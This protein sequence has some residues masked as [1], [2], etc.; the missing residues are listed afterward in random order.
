MPENDAPTKAEFDA[1]KKTVTDLTSKV[2]EV[3]KDAAIYVDRDID[4]QSKDVISQI[5]SE[6][7]PGIWWDEIF[8]VSSVFESIDRVLTGGT[9]NASISSDGLLLDNTGGTISAILSQQ[10]NSPV[11]PAKETFVSTTVKIDDV[12]DAVFTFDFVS[13]GTHQV[14]IKVNAGTIQGLCTGA[15]GTTTIT[16]GTAVDNQ[17]VSLEAHYFPG[18]KVEFFVNDTLTG[19]VTSNLPATTISVDRLVGFGLENAFLGSTAAA[20]V[21]Y[22]SLLQKTKNE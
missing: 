14:R 19:T 5:I 10:V 22:F 20:T 2:E 3:A 1:L 9:G 21:T 18:S 13:D 11:S 7:L 15:S 6:R 16:L 8:Y 12:S 4:N 17:I